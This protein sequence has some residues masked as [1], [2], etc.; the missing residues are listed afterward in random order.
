ME[1]LFVALFGAVIGLAARY[2]LPGRSTQGSVLV[3]AIGTAAASL[4]W[5]ALTWLGWNWAGGWIWWLSLGTSAVASVVLNL[6][7]SRRRIHADQR[8]L[9]RLAKTGAPEVA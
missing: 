5:V 1:L 9:Q 7:I 2:F 6:V 4:V 3:P 8:M